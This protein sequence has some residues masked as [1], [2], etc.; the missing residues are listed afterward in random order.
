[1]SLSRQK[2]HGDFVSFPQEN[3][4][5]GYASAL[6]ITERKPIRFTEFPDMPPQ[7]GAAALCLDRAYKL[8]LC[9]PLDT[10]AHTLR[11]W[12]YAFDFPKEFEFKT[13]GFLWAIEYYSNIFTRGG[14][15][16][17]YRHEF[18]QPLEIARL[19]MRFYLEDPNRKGPPPVSWED[20]FFYLARG[21]Y[22]KKIFSN[23][24]GFIA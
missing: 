13:W 23:E 8:L 17:E 19:K 21:V 12:K 16:V 22:R 20:D 10:A 24:Q 3:K 5:V 2:K 14:D 6:F 9:V 11:G 1:M 18:K 4:F 15:F 7:R